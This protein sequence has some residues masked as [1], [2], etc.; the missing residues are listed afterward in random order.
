MLKTIVLAQLAPKLR[1]QSR[2]RL[3]FRKFKFKF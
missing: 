3:I 1:F 2:S